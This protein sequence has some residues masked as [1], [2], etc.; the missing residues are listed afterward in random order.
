MKKPR[1]LVTGA[2]C[3]IGYAVSRQ[4]AVEGYRPKLM[5]RRPLREGSL[6]DFD[7]DFVEANLRNP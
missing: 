7:A 6:R 5:I 4:L 3:F 1:F 2:T